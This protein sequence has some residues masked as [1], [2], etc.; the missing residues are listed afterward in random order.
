MCRLTGYLHMDIY[1][2]YRRSKLFMK[3]D[4]VSPTDLAEMINQA[5]IRA[6]SDLRTSRM[7]V[8]QVIAGHMKT[9]WIRE[10]LAEIL[11]EPFEDLWPYGYERRRIA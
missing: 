11:G 9:R 3:F 5:Q 2:K 8:H 7:I 6:G 1:R 10:A 4:K